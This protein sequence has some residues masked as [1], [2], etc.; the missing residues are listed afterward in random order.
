M[1]AGAEPTAD[2]FASMAAAI[3]AAGERYALARIAEVQAE[4][5]VAGA[6]EARALGR[7]LAL[8]SDRLAAGAGLDADT[9]GLAGERYRARLDAAREVGLA[10]PEAW[11]RR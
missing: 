10:D 3:G 11:A 7:S 1:T 6:D 5:A 4:L 8:L 2:P 9:G